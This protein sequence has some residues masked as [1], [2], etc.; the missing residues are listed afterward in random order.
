MGPPEAFELEENEEEMIKPARKLK[1]NVNVGESNSR[2]GTT[3]TSD[4][5]YGLGVGSSNDPKLAQTHRELMEEQRSWQQAEGSDDQYSADVTAARRGL[6]KEKSGEAAQ[7]Q[8][9]LALV[10]ELARTL[11]ESM[12]E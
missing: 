7:L 12:Q 6:T 4:D 1:E 10:I 8:R 3:N 5:V 9:A 2:D 11:R